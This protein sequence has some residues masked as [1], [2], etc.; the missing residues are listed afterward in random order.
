MEPELEFSSTSEPTSTTSEDPLVD[1][2]YFD[3]EISTS[4]SSSTP[5]YVDWET[6]TP[7]FEEGEVTT[8]DPDSLEPESSEFLGKIVCPPCCGECFPQCSKFRKQPFLLIS[9]FFEPR[10]F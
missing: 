9:C 8:P 1:Y 2:L 5:E 4:T 7:K 6:S 10:A 3:P